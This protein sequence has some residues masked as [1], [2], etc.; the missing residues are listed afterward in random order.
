MRITRETLLKHARQT[1]TFRMAQDKTVVCVYLTGSLLNEDPVI[2]GTADIDLIF[3]H[4]RLPKVEREVIRV[5]DEVTFDIAHYSQ[6][7]YDQPR[8]LR[9][10]PWLG[11]YLIADPI[12]L[13]ENQHWFEFTQASVAAQFYQP[14]TILAR[15]RPLA[16]F[17]RQVWMDLSSKPVEVGIPPLQTYLKALESAGNAVACLYGPPL[18]ERRF[19]SLFPRRASK[20]G[21]PDLTASMIGLFV[22]QPPADEQWAGWLIDWENAFNTISTLSS[23][24]VKLKPPRKAYYLNAMQALREEN[25]PGALWILLRS[26]TALAAHLRSNAA[27]L[28]PY[29]EFRR[30]LGLDEGSLKARFADLDKFLDRVDDTLD[31]FALKSGIR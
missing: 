19:F 3:V 14:D 17:S 30:V 28:H 31:D 24:P 6:M 11:S 27:A 1:V 15:V 26:W 7:N 2:G 25:A 4:D 10:N 12:L 21:K 23:C 20:A 16:D 29:N 13:F 18:P 8:R 5:T 9:L 22:R